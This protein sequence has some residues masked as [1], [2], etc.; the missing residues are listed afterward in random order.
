[1]SLSVL[2][3]DDEPAVLASLRRMLH[4]TRRQWEPRFVTSA[5][6]AI[7]L[8]ETV[9]FDAIVSDSQMP[10]MDGAALLE[11]TKANH[12]SV[13]RIMLSGEVKTDA[14]L[15]VAA[16][17]HQFLQKPCPAETLCAVIERVA[18]LQRIVTNPAALALVTGIGALPTPPAT[19]G[20]LNALLADES[21]SMD[22][23]A[24]S[25]S[26]DVAVSAKVLQMVNSAFFGVRTRVESV[27]R[28]C[29]ML[30]RRAL[31]SLVAAD[32]IL[33]LCDGVSPDFIA[34][35]ETH[36]QEIARLAADGAPRELR[37]R[38]LSVG[39]LH[40]IGWL[41][42]ADG[43]PDRFAEYLR[44]SPGMA[45]NP[46]VERAVFGALH[47]E[48]GAALLTL[49]GL[50]EEVV[51]AV[52]WHHGAHLPKGHVADLILRAHETV[53]ATSY[54]PIAPRSATG[55]APRTENPVG[56]RMP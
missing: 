54:L 32:G 40:D 30:G 7:E 9:R 24:S 11:R 49:W 41:L 45:A 10:G 29:G 37:E 35:L 36:S 14:A 22:Q 33:R 15:R 50:P 6:A 12:P 34:R 4:Q 48:V 38:A 5:D 53:D 20:R 44:R 42:L 51:E 46:E 43:A 17:A 55:S 26:D 27:P 31:Q 13:A 23:V 19:V 18:S 16:A 1:M 3:V 52:A 25:V 2:F 28:A 21:A 47:E 39:I 56:S 8:L